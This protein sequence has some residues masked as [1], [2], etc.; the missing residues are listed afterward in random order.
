MSLK[1]RL[2]KLEA[3]RPAGG[4]SHPWH[5]EHVIWTG[6][7]GDEPPRCP[8]CNREPD[9]QFVITRRDATVPTLK[10]ECEP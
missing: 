4:C 10:K 8:L 1:A 7:A 3:S 2:A 6:R 9:Y 5:A